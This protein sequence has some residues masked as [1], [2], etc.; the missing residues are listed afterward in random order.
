MIPAFFILGLSGYHAC[1]GTDGSVDY[2]GYT[3]Y[4]VSSARWMISAGDLK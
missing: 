3:D 4:M 2:A 1:I